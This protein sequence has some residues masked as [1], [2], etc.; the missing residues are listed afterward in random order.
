[1]DVASHELHV[2]DDWSVCVDHSEGPP[3]T[4][5]SE[6]FRE[7]SCLSCAESHDSEIALS[8]HL[9]AGKSVAFLA[10]GFVVL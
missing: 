7:I 8:P 10:I 5:S 6:K 9:K 4:A 3:S 1:M 2:W